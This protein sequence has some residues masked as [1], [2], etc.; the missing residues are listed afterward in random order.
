MIDS[1]AN[2][3]FISERFVKQHGIATRQKGIGYG[4]TAVD[5]SRLPDIDRETDTIR[6]AHQQH[7][8][9]TS[10]DV[11]VMAKHDIVLGMPWLTWH[12]PS[13]DW[14]KRVLKFDKCRCVARAY[15][16]RRQRMAKDEIREFNYTRKRTRSKGKTAEALSPPADTDSGQSGPKEA[17]SNDGGHAPSGLPKEYHQWKRLFEEEEGP[18]ALPKHQPW[19]HKI[20]LEPGKEPPWGP[21]YPQSEKELSATRDWLSKMEKKGWIRKSK[22]PA[23]TPTLFVPKANGKLRMVQDYRK[24]NAITIKN[25]YPLPNIEEAMDR[26]SGANW[27]TKID[28]RDAFY[29]IRM[30]EGE[31]WKTA[32]RTRYGHYEFLVMP[33]G[34]TNAPASCQQLVNDTLRD[35]LDITVVAYLDDI[36][37]YTT[38]PLQQHT[39]DVQAVFERLSKTSFKTAPEK[40]EFHQKNVKFLGFIIGTDG[41][42]ID[43]EKTKSI[44]EWPV[45]K[46]LTQVQSSWDLLTT[47]GSSFKIIRRRQYP[48][49]HLQGRIRLSTGERNNNKPSTQ[50]KNLAW[51][52]QY[53]ESTMENKKS[54]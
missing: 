5:G 2:G 21:I 39:K 41:I 48:L 23:G 17:R 1:G 7:L 27:F 14:K 16:L 8:E 53:F 25:R 31:E 19:D 9:D 50:S 32:F 20:Q 37:I 3:C 22:S 44:Q 30:A 29:S 35:L 28:L 34:L 43:P 46:T 42:K 38:G 11:V 52:H 24:L 49:Q 18:N 12:N 6:L 40:C 36:L 45:P 54:T 10:L 15:P 4:L 33:M 51:K 47:T 13:I 26:L